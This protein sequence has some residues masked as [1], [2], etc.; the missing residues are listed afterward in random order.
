MRRQASKNGS[1]HGCC[2]R[3]SEHCSCPANEP[4]HYTAI[5]DSRLTTKY[6]CLAGPS[7]ACHGPINY[8][9][10]GTPPKQS[11]KPAPTPKRSNESPQALKRTRADRRNPTAA[12]NKTATRPRA[13]DLIV[14]PTPFESSLVQAPFGSNPLHHL[15]DGYRASLTAVSCLVLGFNVWGLGFKVEV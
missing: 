5:A 7:V 3:R 11:P 13:G 8:L 1:K 15:L 14:R 6:G 12:R 9:L 10:P 2:E 4:T